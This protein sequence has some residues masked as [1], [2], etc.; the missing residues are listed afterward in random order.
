VG[1][2]VPLVFEV[3]DLLLTA[4]K[5]CW[6][7]QGLFK[8]AGRVYKRGGLLLEKVIEAPFAGGERQL[9]GVTYNRSEAVGPSRGG[10]ARFA[11]DRTPPVF[12]TPT[13]L[14]LLEQVSCHVLSHL[15]RPQTRY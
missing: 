11:V 8:K 14:T 6:D 9:Y 4:R 3:L 12:C 13:R 5:V 1:G 15:P 10:R 7:G 2:F